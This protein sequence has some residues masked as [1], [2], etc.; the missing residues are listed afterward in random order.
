MR[1]SAL[2]IMLLGISCASVNRPINILPEDC[3]YRHDCRLVTVD[4]TS[5][6]YNVDLRINNRKYG[7]VPAYSTRVFSLFTSELNHGNCAVVTAKFSGYSKQLV[8]DERCINDGEY[9][10]VQLTSSPMQIWLTPF[11]VR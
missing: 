3:Q 1:L 5:N 9:Y 7:D 11:R 6:Q 2:V 8:S 10:N 4:N